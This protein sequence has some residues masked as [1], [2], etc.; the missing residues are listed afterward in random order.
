MNLKIGRDGNTTSDHCKHICVLTQ[1][2]KQRWMPVYRLLAARFSTD[3]KQLPGVPWFLGIPGNPGINS[4][5]QIALILLEFWRA[6]NACVAM[7]A[8]QWATCCLIFSWFEATLGFLQ[9]YQEGRGSTHWGGSRPPKPPRGGIVPM[10]LRLILL[11]SFKLKLNHL[12]PMYG[13][14]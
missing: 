1:I 13:G 8:S 5:L 2:W 9:F 4:R 3:L 12:N 14:R 11:M 10:T 6:Q 7:T